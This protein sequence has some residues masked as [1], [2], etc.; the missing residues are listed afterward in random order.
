MENKTKD[1]TKEIFPLL[2][3]SIEK[4][5]WYDSRPSHP[6]FIFGRLEFRIHIDPVL[7]KEAWRIALSRQP[8]A[9]VKPEKVKRRWHWGAKSQTNER[10][11]TGSFNHHESESSPE[12]WNF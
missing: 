11:S 4:F 6:N 9:G 8:L 7:A 12:P 1:L 10:G 5:H 2:M 3:S